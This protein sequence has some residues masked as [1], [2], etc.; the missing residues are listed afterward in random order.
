VR[1]GKQYFL[2]VL[3]CGK[4]SE[5]FFRSIEKQIGILR[6]DGQHVFDQAL[7][8]RTEPAVLVHGAQHY[9]DLHKPISIVIL[10]REDSCGVQT[11]IKGV[12]H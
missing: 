7:D 4:P 12:L 1:R 9:G 5:I 3:V 8:V 6:I 10:G 2:D 11:W